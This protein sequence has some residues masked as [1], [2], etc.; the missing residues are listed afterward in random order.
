M[1]LCKSCVI[2]SLQRAFF[3]IFLFCLCFISAVASFFSAYFFL[4]SIKVD[5]C[6][7]FCC[8]H[9]MHRINAIQLKLMGECVERLQK[10]FLI[11]MM[12]RAIL[13]DYYLFCGA[14][15]KRFPV[16]STLVHCLFYTNSLYL[17]ELGQ[18]NCFTSIVFII[19]IILRHYLCLVI[20]WFFSFMQLLF[21]LRLICFL[22]SSTISV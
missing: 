11:L 17:F 15:S 7:F 9:M 12:C 16:F 1:P 19:P 20:P 10:M 2:E 5:V 8:C 3:L 6:F 21:R 22:F 4:F 14:K 13:I 18:R